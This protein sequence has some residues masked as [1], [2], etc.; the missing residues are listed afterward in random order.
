[1][2]EIERLEKEAEKKEI[3]DQQE[4]SKIN[5]EKKLFCKG[6][7]KVKPLVDANQKL[8]I[9]PVCQLEEVMVMSNTCH[10]ALCQPCWDQWLD[11]DLRCPI[12]RGRVRKNFLVS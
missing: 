3:I 2:S 10:H 9:C 8:E 1:M 5:Y 12:C 7:K 6:R 11:Q 4:S